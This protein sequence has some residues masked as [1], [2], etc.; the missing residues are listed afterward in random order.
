M[1]RKVLTILA[2]TIL[3]VV[4]LLASTCEGSVDITTPER[5]AQRLEMMA[6]TVRTE[7]E[8]RDVDA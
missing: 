4:V 7:A 8:L 1:K 2:Y 5:D 6:R 3:V